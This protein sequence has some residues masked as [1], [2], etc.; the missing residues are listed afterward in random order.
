M[1]TQIKLESPFLSFLFSM[2][3]RTEFLKTIQTKGDLHN[4]ISQVY[5]IPEIKDN[6]CT[7]EYLEMYLSDNIPVTTIKRDEMTL[8]DFK[9]EGDD[10]RFLLEFYERILFNKGLSPTGNPPKLDSLM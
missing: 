8:H 9:Y 7:L 4:M 1:E 3:D 6:A 10:Q 5:F 2:V